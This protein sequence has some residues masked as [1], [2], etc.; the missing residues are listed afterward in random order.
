MVMRAADGQ[1]YAFASQ[2]ETDSGFINI[3]VAR[4]RDMVEWEQLRDALPLKPRWAEQTQEFRAPHVVELDGV[5]LL[6]YSAK[7]DPGTVNA[8]RGE[9]C[10]NVAAAEGSLEGPYMDQGFPLHCVAGSVNMS[11]MAFDDPRTGRRLLY[12]NSGSRYTARELSATPGRFDPRSNPVDLVV[13]QSS[14][15]G[16]ASRVVL[17]GIWV[18]YREPYYYLLYSRRECCSATAQNSIMV[19]RSGSATGPFE[20]RTQGTVSSEVTLLAPAA[21]GGIGRISVVRDA[22]GQEWLVYD[23]VKSLGS[24]S[25]KGA[26]NPSKVLQMDRLVYREGWPQIDPD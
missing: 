22:G 24:D 4:S 26:V 1:Y 2:V 8:F 6:Y 18:T 21:L 17:D 12:W 25:T 19:A 9:T 16:T 3:Q 14:P 15:A 11:P 7:P 20:G 13:P 5:S 10:M 23:V